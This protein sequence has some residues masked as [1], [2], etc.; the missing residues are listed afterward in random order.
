MKRRKATAAPPPPL[1]REALEA[2]L[3]R[4]AADY[5]AFIESWVRADPPD[6]KAF[7]AHQAAARSALAH[8][9]ELASLATGEPP[10]EEAMQDIAATIER[11]RQALARDAEE[12]GRG[13]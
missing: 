3:D 7:S 2:A 9:V 8:L 10:S 11:A 5:T 6:P 13:A 12:E 1:K 4:V